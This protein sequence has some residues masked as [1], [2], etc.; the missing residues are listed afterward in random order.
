MRHREVGE[1]MPRE[2]VT[3]PRGAAFRDIVRALCE[4]QL[5][6]VAVVDSVGDPLGVVLEGDLLPKSATQGGC[7]SSLSAP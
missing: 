6:A 4:H 5:S 7:L 2:V 1:L 3:V